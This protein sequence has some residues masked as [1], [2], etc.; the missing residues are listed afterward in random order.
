MTTPPHSDS[1][2]ALLAPYFAA[3]R[4]SGSGLNTPSH[5][6]KELLAAFA[7]RFPK[8]RWYQRLSMQQWGAAGGLVTGAGTMVMLVFMMTMQAPDRVGHPANPLGEGGDFIA[9][10]SRERIELEAAPRLVEAT[11]PR[12]ALAGLDGALTP[13][14]AGDTVRAQLLIGADGEPLALRLLPE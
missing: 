14:T 13:Q 10:E 3:L 11:L 9:I 7:K 4:D 12:T 2:E 5:V 8:K 1:D 6:E